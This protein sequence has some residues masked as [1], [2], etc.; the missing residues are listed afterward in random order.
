MLKYPGDVSV[1]CVHSVANNA[2]VPCV[3]VT[4]GFRDKDELIECGADYLADS[5][6]GLEAIL[7]DILTKTGE[8]TE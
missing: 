7:L 8:R 2:G 6:D 1:S 4:W 3:C 5:A